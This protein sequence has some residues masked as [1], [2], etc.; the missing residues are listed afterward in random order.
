MRKVPSDRGGWKIAAEFRSL[1][2]NTQAPR[3]EQTGTVVPLQPRT[4]LF[5]GSMLNNQKD[6]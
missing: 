4:K 5:V 1:G 6:P 2:A 3:K